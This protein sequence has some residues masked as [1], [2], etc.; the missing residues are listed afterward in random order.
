M[1]AK[2]SPEGQ[3]PRFATSEGSGRPLVFLKMHFIMCESAGID[4]KWNKKKKNGFAIYHK[5]SYQ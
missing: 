1:F 4:D 2:D 3:T 5:L